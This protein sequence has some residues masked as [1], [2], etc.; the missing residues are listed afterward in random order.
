MEVNR[1]MGQVLNVVWVKINENSLVLD[2]QPKKK[3]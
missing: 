2:Y 3:Y 1:D